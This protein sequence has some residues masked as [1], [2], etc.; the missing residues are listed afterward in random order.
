VAS[1]SSSDG[2][3]SFALAGV[4]GAGMGCAAVTAADTASGVAVTD[5]WCG[6]FALPGLAGEGEAT[7]V[8]AGVAGGVGGRVGAIK[9]RVTRC[10]TAGASGRLR[11]P[12]SNT[13]S[14]A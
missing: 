1:V 7:G 2:S 13:I 3:G 5:G 11:D 6:R 12:P 14:A 10:G 9:R 4:A 8:G